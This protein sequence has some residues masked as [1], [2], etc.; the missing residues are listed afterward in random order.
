M[1]FNSH[2]ACGQGASALAVARYAVGSAEFKRLHDD[3]TR[4]SLSGVDPQILFALLERTHLGATVST[5]VS[6][7]M[8]LAGHLRPLVTYQRYFARVIESELR[9]LAA[10]LSESSIVATLLKGP[11]L[12]ELSYGDKALRRVHDLDILVS[13]VDQMCQFV[14]VAGATGY[15]TPVDYDR[16]SILLSDHYELPALT[17]EITHKID[18]TIRLDLESFSRNSAFDTRISIE[19]D[20]CITVSVDLE[21]HRGLFVYQDGSIPPISSYLLQKSRE[22]GPLRVM[23]PC[24]LL[25][26]LALKFVLDAKR[27][28]KISDGTAKCVKLLMDFISVLTTAPYSEIV[29]S[30]QVAEDL[31]IENE[32][33][34]ALRHAQSLTPEIDM[35]NLSGPATTELLDALCMMVFEK[36]TK[37]EVVRESSS[38]VSP[39]SS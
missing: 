24:L 2:T 4:T 34:L 12:W 21:P 18:D 17:K 29:D 6:P 7:E 19:S 16:L 30:I 39:F 5:I 20:G 37:N 28:L 36:A 38:L 27:A 13:D 14:R 15:K 26:Y 9:A 32:Y 31:R 25:P 35:V 1:D 8:S 23:R 3:N 33:D 10:A 22:F 11:S